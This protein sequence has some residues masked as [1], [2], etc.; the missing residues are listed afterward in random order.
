MQGYFQEFQANE[1]IC[2]Q[3]DPSTDLYFLKKGSLLVCTISGTQVKAV[4]RIHA[5]EFIGEL[6]FFDGQARSG[7]II[8]TRAGK[9][10]RIPKAEISPLLPYW[11]LQVGIGLTKKIRLLDHAI[12]NANI[13]KTTQADNKPLTIEEQ[14]MFYEI[15]SK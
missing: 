1:V 14:R 7:H 9:L 8:A 4:A 2:R 10:I 5:G 6:S 3:G 11:Y 13:R 12:H 15:L